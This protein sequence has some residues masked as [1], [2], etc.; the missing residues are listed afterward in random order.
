MKRITTK[1]I[2]IIC[3]AAMLLSMASC[4]G[5][6]HG[7]GSSGGGRTEE[8]GIKQE[9]GR[10]TDPT[11]NTDPTTDPTSD[12]TTDPTTTPTGRNG[13]YI[14]TSDTLTYPDHVAAFE[15]VHP[16]HPA[17]NISGKEA[18]TLL[19]DVESAIL[20]HEITCYAD[21]EKARKELGYS[22][23]SVRQSVQDMVDWIR[24]YEGEK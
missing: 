9:G 12:P 8:S 21:A 18:L 22:P 5:R 20:K 13:D 10:T 17:G 14:P 11:R 3:C 24:E 7:G 1:I 16:D 23:M 19:T 2:A 6:R 4:T 15:E